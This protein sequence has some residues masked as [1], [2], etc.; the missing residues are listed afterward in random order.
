MST[1]LWVF[2][3]KIGTTLFANTDMLVANQ[4]LG[5]KTAGMFGALLMI[6]KNLRVIGQALGS[7]WG[8]TFLMK[9]SNSDIKGMDQVIQRTVKLIGFSMALPVGLIAGLAKP[10]LVTWLGPEYEIMSWVLVV[11]V[12]H[13]SV[14][15]ISTPF[16]NIQVTL[17]KLALPAGFSLVLG[18]INFFLAVSFSRVIGAMGI[19][20]AGALTLTTDNLIIMP[21]YTAN[22]M[23]KKWWH[24]LHKM[25]PVMISALGVALSSYLTTLIF[26][27][28]NLFSLLLV[29]TII[30]SIY[31][32]IIYLFGLSASDREMI[33]DL[34]VNS[35]SG[36]PG[37]NRVIK[38]WGL[39][40]STYE[41][42]DD[43]A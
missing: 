15:L 18:V 35:I 27:L 8:P 3:Y 5:L 1:S 40:I 21:I 14:N 33:I 7:V 36:F 34:L 41:N 2:I 9:F 6:P 24:Y 30:S 29:G 38:A 4:T 11:M 12:V 22:I 25:T 17:N 10:F 19:V 43:A 26:P 39:Q 16:L 37:L 42:K 28:I 13:L 31:L 32:P 23:D 20:A